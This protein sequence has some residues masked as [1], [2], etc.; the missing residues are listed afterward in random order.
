[1]SQ[2]FPARLSRFSTYCKFHIFPTTTSWSYPCRVLSGVR[3][4]RLYT[5][6]LKG[7]GILRWAPSILTFPPHSTHSHTYARQHRA[8]QPLAGIRV[9][10][11]AW[12]AEPWQLGPGQGRAGQGADLH[13]ACQGTTDDGSTSIPQHDFIFSRFKIPYCHCRVSQG[14]FL[15]LSL[16]RVAGE[17]S[18][19]PSPAAQT[20]HVS[21]TNHSYS[22][23]SSW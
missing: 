15:Y 18:I 10:F 2:L 8:P 1:M 20:E 9:S 23:S 16:L 22:L 11:P 7:E 3:I 6:V 19:S 17:G 12:P 14:F 4:N 21:T 5:P 13:Q